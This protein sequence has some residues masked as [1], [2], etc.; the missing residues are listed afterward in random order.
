M[1]ER[2][3]LSA[4]NKDINLSLKTVRYL[5]VLSRKTVRYLIAG[6]FVAAFNLLLAACLHLTGHPA[7]KLTATHPLIAMALLIGLDA[8]LWIL[9]YRLIR[10]ISPI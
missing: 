9:F 7:A 10:R 5:I 1:N 4:V 6:L 3:D 8:L 2:L